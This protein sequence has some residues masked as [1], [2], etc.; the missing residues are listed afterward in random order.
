MIDIKT[1]NVNIEHTTT[2]WT[3]EKQF[4][5]NPIYKRGAFRIDPVFPQYKFT[6]SELTKANTK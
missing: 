3:S 6:S 4:K 1:A 5:P 2:S